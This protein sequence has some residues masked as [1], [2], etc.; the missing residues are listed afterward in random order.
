MQWSAPAP[1][2]E[3]GSIQIRNTCTVD[4]FLTGVTLFKKV[5]NADLSS[6]FPKDREHKNLV[7]TLD[8]AD[9]KQFNKAQVKYFRELEQMN[10]SFLTLASTKAQLEEI[11]QR[12]QEIERIK[13][14]NA[15][16]DI[17]NKN[18]ER[19]NKNYP[20]RH[21]ME[22]KEYKQVP[23]PKQIAKPIP[24]LREEDLWG[25]ICSRVH[26]KHRRGYDFSVKSSCSNP[27]CAHHQERE[28]IDYQVH[29]GHY[30]NREGGIQSIGDISQI[31]TG[32]SHVCE[33]CKTG[34][35]TDK[36]VEIAQGHW[37]LS[38]DCASLKQENQS[39]AKQDILDKRLPDTIT[40]RTRGK[41]S[42]KVCYGLATINLNDEGSHFISAHWIPSEREFVYY[43]GMGPGDKI[44]KL[45]RSDFFKPNRQLAS[46]E[47]YKLK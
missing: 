17:H 43:D 28:M 41:R 23:S 9:R 39:K 34:K 21:P 31:L 6:C 36:K 11:E 5:Q 27:V 2:N 45:Q 7:E 10:E 35:W 1:P 40:L 46:V 18:A 47:Y 38:F 20:G 15:K 14:E 12:N 37:A 33:G 32:D 30:M 19:H 8:L 26:L 3:K 16:I 22:I 29:L 25:S 4:N 42:R 13:E 24:D 44:R